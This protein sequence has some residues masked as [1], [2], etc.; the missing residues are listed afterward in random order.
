MNDLREAY[1]AGYMSGCIDMELW[2]MA[3]SQVEAESSYET[4]N[5]PPDSVQPGQKE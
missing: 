5:N 2:G 3:G 1:I 4:W